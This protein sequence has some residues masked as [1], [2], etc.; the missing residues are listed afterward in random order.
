[1]ITY[2]R[3]I[4]QE[5]HVW[6]D[7]SNIVYSKCYDNDTNK[8]KTLKIVFKGGRTY[9]YK[10]VDSDDYIRFKMSQSTGDGFNRYIKNAKTVM[11]I[12]D[13]D[14]E[15]LEKLRED[16]KNENQTIEKQKVGDLVYNIMIDKQ[17]N[18]FIIKMGERVLFRGIERQFSILNLFT[19]LNIKYGFTE[20]D[21]LENNSDEELDE[22]KL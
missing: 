11:R 4:N 5:D 20:V 10:E 16:F 12:A 9:V 8:G 1:M 3:Y 6:Y 7:S 19:S 21:S 18:E 15:K 2:N 17:T 22:I 13:T 14:L